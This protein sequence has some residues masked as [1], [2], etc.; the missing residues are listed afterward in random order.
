MKRFLALLLTLVMLVSVCGLQAFAADGDTSADTG[1]E[2]VVYTRSGAT[3]TF[4]VGDTFSYTYWFRLTSGSVN[5]ITGH[6]LYDSQCLSVNAD[7]CKFPN[8]T[9]PS[10]KN[11]AGDFEFHDTFT[12][13]Q[14]GE[15]ATTSPQIM[16]NISFTVTRGG[17][18]Y[19]TTLLEELEI[20]KS[21]GKESELVTNCK[22]KTWSPA[23]YSTFDYLQDEKPSLASTPLSVELRIAAT[24]NGVKPAP[25]ALMGSITSFATGPPSPMDEDTRS[26]PG[27]SRISAC[28]CWSSALSVS[29]LL[30]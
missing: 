26:T 12:T 1:D 3:R 9:S 20:R 13:S 2:L 11:N 25:A 4:H 30:A 19:L 23:M 21:N 18:A 5:K 17:T 22:N 10:T 28:T 14:G 6:V 29:R 16:A 27:I 7:G 8:M 15:F 24:W